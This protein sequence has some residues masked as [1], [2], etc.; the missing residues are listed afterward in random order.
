MFD[1]GK[2]LEANPDQ[3]AIIK[4]LMMTT[5]PTSGSYALDAPAT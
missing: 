2:F 4:P 5:D 1:L 3:L